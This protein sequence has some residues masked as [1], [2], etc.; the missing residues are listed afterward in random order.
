[1]NIKKTMI[2]EIRDNDHQ[3]EMKESIIASAVKW[4]KIWKNPRVF[5]W[6]RHCHCFRE[7]YLS[8][9]REPM[10]WMEDQ[11]FLTSKNRYVDR[12][13]WLEIAKEFGQVWENVNWILFSEDLR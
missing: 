3:W 1:M 12:Y 10:Q 2:D 6:K 9:W 8:D 5:I 7:I 13:E 11:W 4:F